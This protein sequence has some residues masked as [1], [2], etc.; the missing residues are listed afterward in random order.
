MSSLGVY[1]CKEASPPEA[2]SLTARLKLYQTSVEPKP[3]LFIDLSADSNWQ[4]PAPLTRGKFYVV[5]KVSATPMFSTEP[6]VPN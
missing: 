2:K 1:C 3:Q 5:T 6:T 4:N